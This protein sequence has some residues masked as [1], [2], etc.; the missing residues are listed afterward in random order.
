MAQ[1]NIDNIKV[2]GTAIVLIIWGVTYT[3]TLPGW[4]IEKLYK[5]LKGG[6]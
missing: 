2:D 6:K 4:V 1:T 3:I 5:N